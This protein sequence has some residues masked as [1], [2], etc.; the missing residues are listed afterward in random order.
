MPFAFI[1]SLLGV[2]S[3]QY[4]SSKSLSV[5]IPFFILAMAL[6]TSFSKEVGVVDEFQGIHR[7]NTFLGRIAS[8]ILGFYDGFFGPGTG[9]FFMFSLVKI[10]KFDFSVATANTKVLNFATGIAA[11]FTFLYNHEVNFKIGLFSLLFMVIGAKLGSKMAIKNGAKFIKPI[12]I[13]MSIVIGG[14]LI[15]QYFPEFFR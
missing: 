11:F 5:I 9:T 1:F 12:F 15:F 7:K 2:V 4:I 13:T 10:F 14:K 3:L 8:S 6:Y